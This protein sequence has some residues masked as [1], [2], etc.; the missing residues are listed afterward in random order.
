MAGKGEEAEL[1]AIL[2]ELERQERDE[3]CRLFVPNG[4]QAKY[5]KNLKRKDVFIGLFIAANGVGKDALLVNL[6]A[7]IVWGPQNEWFD[8][9]LFRK[10]PFPKRLRVGTEANNMDESGSI[11]TEVSTWF[12]KGRYH[13]LKGGKPWFTSYRTDQGFL[14]DKMSYQ[15]EVRE[16]EA[17]TLGACFFS[18][19][20][21]REI[22]SATVGRMRKGG[23]IG[24][25]M[26]P[27]QHSAWIQDELVDSYSHDTFVVT[28]DIEQNCKQ[29][30]IRGVL[31]H[32]H[33]GRMIAKWDQDEIEARA[34]G[35]FM[36]ISRVILGKSFKRNV[37]VV[38]NHVTPPEG[39]RWF[40]VVDPAKGKPWA[41]AWGWV[42]KRGQ[43]VFDHEYPEEEFI[44]MRES[45]LGIQDYNQILRRGDQGKYMEWEIIDRHFA[46]TR[47]AR[48]MTLKGL[49]NNDYGF[50]FRDSYNCENEIE[51]GIQ[52]MKDYLRF[53]ESRPLDA[54]N[55]PRFLVKERCR[56]TIRSL[57]RWARD[58]LTLEPDRRSPYK[59]HFDLARY[60]CM[61]NMRIYE[62]WKP[63]ERE[64]VYAVGR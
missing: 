40:R 35:R 39:S 49:L 32:E 23:L 3:K 63:L 43:I 59:D 48:N 36:H 53:D 13:G 10:W 19:P 44:R 56:N 46:N 7:N 29:H 17:A 20:P 30:G 27:L 52:R 38:G 25:F 11:D 4:L 22:F 34:H 62:D 37:H 61:A 24:F 2:G 31:E 33:I 54:F 45:S 57:E 14:I 16:W 64:K 42:D 12:P 6:L 21:S 41:I 8:L 9:P 55:F 18:E 26:T 58:P 50:R 5:I 28:G 47:D 60:A 15:Q 1:R 51:I